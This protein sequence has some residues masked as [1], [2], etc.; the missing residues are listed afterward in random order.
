MSLDVSPDGKTVAFD[1]L[2]DLYLLPIEGG[3]AR[4][5][6]SG[7]PWD[8]Q[9]RFSPD[10]AQLAFTSDRAGG[11]NLWVLTLSSP[12]KPKAITEEK[13]R[14]L[15]QPVW[16]PSG[17]YLAGRRHFTGT[18]SLGA[19]EIWSYHTGEKSGGAQLTKRA[20]D[21]LD[22]GE[23]A[24]SP[25]GRYLYYSLDATGG[26][27]FQ[28]N[29]DPNAGI[30]A[31]ERLDRVSGK[32]T[33]V[34]GGSGGACTPTPSPD[35][36]WLAFVRRIRG[37]TVLML[38]EL[39]SGRETPLF[40]GLDRDMQETWA[41]HGVYPRMA[42]MP[43]SREL[44]FWASGRLWRMAA[45][46]GATPREIPFHVKDSR[47]VREAVRFPVEVAPAQV[48]VKAVRMTTVTGDGRTVYFSALGKLWSKEL[49]G[50][51]P[52][53][54]VT[55]ATSGHESHPRLVSNDTQLL[56]VTWSDQDLGT[57]RL[58]ALASGAETILV[59]NGRF[60][61]VALSPDGTK[62]AYRRLSRIALYSPLYTEAPG[63][64]LMDL[65]SPGR[66][67]LL[68]D[69]G[70]GDPQFDA[71]SKAL[72]FVRGG[73]Q[74]QLVRKDLGTFEERVLYQGPDLSAIGLSPDGKRG[75]FQEYLNL[76]TFSPT[77]TGRTVEI[78]SAAQ[79][80]P[81]RKVSTELGSYFP[82][83]TSRGDLAWNVGP[84]LFRDNGKEPF[85]LSWSV[86][87]YQPPAE[88][89]VALVG[90][91]VVSM[92]GDEVIADGTVLVKGARI[93]AVGPS[94]SVAVPTGAKVLD[95]RGKTVLPG[96]VDVHWH[97][98]FSDGEILP[99]T[100]WVG[101]SSLSFGV[102]TL[103]DP[104]NDTASV[105]SAKELQRVGELVAPRIFS[106]GT[107]LYGAR[108]PGYYAAVNSLSDARGHLRRL[109][110]WGA[111]SV[112]SYNQPRRDQ[113][114]QIL[115]AAR[116]EHMMVVPEGGSLLE[117]NLTMVVDGHTGIEHG[118]P[119]A[120]IYDDVVSLWSGTKVGYTP[121]LGVA[122]GGLWGEN[123]WYVET[124]VW[125]D[126][127]LN[128]FVPREVIDPGARR[129]VHVPDEEHNHIN[130]SR[131]AAR[132]ARAGVKV[133]LGAHGQRE[134]L[135]AHWELAM[136]VQ[137]GM[138][139]HQ[140]LRC[141]T[142]NG[143][144]YLGMD[145]DLGSLEVGKLADIIVVDGDPLVDILESK[146]VEWTISGGR[147]FDAASMKEL[148]P[149]TGTEPKL[150]WKQ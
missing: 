22:L 70:G 2:G 143:A 137:G 19:G 83:Y 135:A 25:D 112:K 59:K 134:G 127:R 116:E 132:L 45:E 141:G 32:I 77:Y 36:K 69:A 11:D 108:A 139:P 129:R 107:I 18:R 145:G 91:R 87:A 27:A 115:E 41:I 147:V 46:P 106:T 72:L 110:T 90:G 103:H 43:D 150:W 13:F 53:R 66:P 73:E 16:D 42:W 52:P 31:I 99:E 24:F 74:T 128:A 81:T 88:A 35:G 30:Y 96:L 28:Y 119:V 29:K 80:V 39:E 84:L 120:E 54:R 10:G 48:P 1:L 9:P 144:R 44:V 125:D 68:I 58:R 97:G 40:D 113:R 111:H 124:D 51:G 118:L 60:A 82:S 61:D 123:F 131:G 75:F 8:M 15:N 38:R 78:G 101:L 148:A 92:R 98:A 93:A 23:P 140:A 102:T 47:A 6:T 64:Y 149:A 5:L 17:P 33:R 122:Y 26:A 4:P 37:K 100:N 136:L 130:T 55:S 95:C 94:A 85:N 146:K 3:E 57:I 65:S 12:G 50:A 133:N 138:T 34:T 79:S 126:R 104:S 67:P 86:P 49:L 21:Q 14:L 109:K 105:F 114:Q 71:Q 121:T 142:L 56:Y 76:Y 7:V 62:L 117:H 63:L 89:V 20:N